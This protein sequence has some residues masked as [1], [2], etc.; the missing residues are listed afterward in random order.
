MTLKKIYFNEISLISIFFKNKHI[1]GRQ[2]ETSVIT[3]F[4]DILETT[5]SIVGLIQI[6]SHTKLE[7]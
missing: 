4:N 3:T 1:S 6:D 7:S 2:K 5:V